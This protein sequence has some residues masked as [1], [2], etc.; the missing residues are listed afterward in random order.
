MHTCALWELAFVT[1][2]I[3]NIKSLYWLHNHHTLLQVNCHLLNLN[4]L[5]YILCYL[6]QHTHFSCY[7]HNIS[8][9]VLSSP[10]QVFFVLGNLFG[11]STH[12]DRLFTFYFLCYG[13]ISYQLI[14]VFGSDEKI[15]ALVQWKKINMCHNKNE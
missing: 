2:I 4:T 11:I 5:H 10:L 3:K 13:D 6:D 7:T 12:I 14:S 15:R 1:L 8:I 9:I